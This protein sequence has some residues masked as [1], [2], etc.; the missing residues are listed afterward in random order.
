[1]KRQSMTWIQSDESAYKKF[2]TCK[3]ARNVM[4]TLFWDTEGVLLAK[5]LFLNW[6]VNKETYCETLFK[7]QAANKRKR[8]RKLSQRI[9]LIH[10]NA[11]PHITALTHL[12]I[13]DFGYDVFPH[14]THFPDFAPS[15]F[16]ALSGLKLDLAGKKHL[17]IAS[18][19][20][21]INGFIRKQDTQYWYAGIAKLIT[22]YTKCLE[23]Y[24]FPRRRTSQLQ[25]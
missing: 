5:Y 17:T 19:K 22:R 14:P 21:S 20:K 16:H 10:D 15:D 12:F 6:S 24:R 18:L 7:L 11:H 3:S 9:V 23:L 4:L 8:L 2:K 13:E 25:N 1:M